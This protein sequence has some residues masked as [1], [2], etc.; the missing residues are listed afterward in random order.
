MIT[1][2]RLATSLGLAALAAFVSPGKSSITKVAAGLPGAQGDAPANKTKRK[3]LL[4]FSLLLAMLSLILIS[5]VS[6]SQ[7]EYELAYV[8]GRTVTINAIE[9]SQNAP[10]QAQADLY[11]VVYPIGWEALGVAPPQCNPCDHEGDG[12]DFFDFHDHVLDSM[13]SDPG[14]G[15]F[16]T[17]W[18]V[19]GVAPAYSFFSGGDPAN[20]QAVGEAYAKHIPT[21]SEL[22]VNELL[23]SKLPDGSP[24]AIEVD[25]GSY[26]L[27]AVVNRNAGR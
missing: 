27:C 11:L 1:K 12:I 2:H 10:H 6:A 9:V 20:D 4:S 16:R 23:E 26:F 19:F 21:K 5:G 7:P 18:H 17:L 22:A 24:V 8:N 13:P 25:T 3:T 15:E 14:H